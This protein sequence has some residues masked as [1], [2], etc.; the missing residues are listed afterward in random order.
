M[1][2]FEQALERTD[3]KTLILSNGSNRRCHNHDGLGRGRSFVLVIFTKFAS[4]SGA[5][6]LN[7]S[8]G[9]TPRLGSLL[10]TFSRCR[11][12]LKTLATGV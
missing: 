1:S 3:G 10:G 8:P 6:F 7:P 5:T 2:N 12:F 11:G 4:V 9:R